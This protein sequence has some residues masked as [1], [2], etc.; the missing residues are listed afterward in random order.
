M[1][2]DSDGSSQD[3]I[4]NEGNASSLSGLFGSVNEVEPDTSPKDKSNK[5][6]LKSLFG[7]VD[8][9]ESVN[10]T[11]LFTDDES[12]ISSRRS[13]SFNSIRSSESMH[14]GVSEVS[15]NSGSVSSASDG[16]SVKEG[17]ENEKL[18][19]CVAMLKLVNDFVFDEME[20]DE[21][22]KSQARL[23]DEDRYQSLRNSVNNVITKNDERISKHGTNLEKYLNFVGN[24]TGL[25]NI[26]TSEKIIELSKNL[27]PEEK[28]GYF[29]RKAMK[30][31]RSVMGFAAGFVLK[32]EDINENNKL[33]KSEKKKI[34][35]S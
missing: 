15:S 10:T 33:S 21:D 7:S 34:K 6:S 27:K 35:I 12:V 20:V 18:A 19:K 32:D 4:D 17:S 2:D 16:G 1:L 3:N 14:S 29:A 30:I 22:Q 24:I 28:T 9:R 13:E 5:S 23:N 31:R 11:G 25:D 8:E 26:I